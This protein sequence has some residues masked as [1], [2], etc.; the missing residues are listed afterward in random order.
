MIFPGKTCPK[1]LR[2]EHSPCLGQRRAPTGTHAHFCIFA[3]FSQVL[4]TSSTPVR[5]NKYL[6][7]ENSQCIDYMIAPH[8]HRHRKS[9]PFRVG[10]SELLYHRIGWSL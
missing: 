4:K 3:I 10:A 2:A 6:L 5:N 9:S 7:A 1:A 8:W